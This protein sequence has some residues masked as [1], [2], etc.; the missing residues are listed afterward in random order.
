MK[1]KCIGGFCD[2][3]LVHVEDYFMREGEYVRVPKPIL[4]VRIEASFDEIPEEIEVC[5]LIYKVATF[6]FKS[7][8]YYWFLIPENWTN[9]EAMLHQFAK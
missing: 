8:D 7:G 6:C 1:L 9:K 5:Y 2:G 3:R 4:S